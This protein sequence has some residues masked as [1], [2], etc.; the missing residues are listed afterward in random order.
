MANARRRKPTAAKEAVEQKV[1]GVE[2]TT[3]SN[4]VKADK[5]EKAVLIK[6]ARDEEGRLT[7]EAKGLTKR[8]AGSDKVLGE[9]LRQV[10]E[11][12]IEKNIL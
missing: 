7:V 9:V 8:I 5:E 4:P 3:S 12:F 6:V 1:E 10:T 2:E 11:E